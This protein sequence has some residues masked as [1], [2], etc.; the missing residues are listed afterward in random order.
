M[1]QESW[2]ETEIQSQAK[3]HTASRTARASDQGRSQWRG[4]QEGREVKKRDPNLDNAAVKKYR[5]IV[6]LQANHIQ[7]EDIAYVVEDS[8]RGLMI[9]E[10]TLLEFM[11]AG[12]PPK[13]VDWMLKNYK[14][15]MPNG[16]HG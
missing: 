13:R 12:Y 2:L 5:E 10:A 8:P 15:M 11:A 6:H 3:A 9:W 16:S 7:R 14:A 4:N 1:R